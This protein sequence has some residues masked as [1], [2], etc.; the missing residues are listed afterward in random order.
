[1][2]KK[3]T[4]APTELPAGV[5]T[6]SFSSLKAWRRCHRLWDYKYN[7]KLRKKVKPVALFRGSLIHDLLDARA[8]G[9]SPEAV[10]KDYRKQHGTLVRENPEVYG[11]TFFDDAWA[12]FQGYCKVYEKESL[13]VIATEARLEVPLTEG[14]TL[15]AILDKV[16]KS[17]K[18]RGAW[19]MD[20]KTHRILP[21]GQVRFS[22]LQT[23]LYHWAWNQ[24]HPEEPARGIVWDYLRTKAPT[25]PD[26]LKKGD[27]L[28]QRKDIDTT[29]EVYL[30]EIEKYGFDPEDYRELLQSLRDR[31]NRFYLRVWLPNP[32]D[33]LVRQIMQE[34]IIT[35]QALGSDNAR[36][37]TGEC[38]RCEYFDLCQA[39]LRGLDS[40]WL[41]ET[42]F[43]PQET[44]KE[45]DS[46][47]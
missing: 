31:P 34:T 40:A 7:R 47:E 15:V 2:R 28:S 26:L 23:V 24:A 32:P 39:E 13:E 10:L 3:R 36:S 41:L 22:D 17:P 8:L 43:Q 4:S 42:D 30:A 37:M 14:L 38:D 16:L 18:Q 6:V 27:S 9:T 5:K 46:D 29:Y 45:V 1:M 25:V 12:I 20:H 21:P 11:E 33:H 19:I 35:G 44:L